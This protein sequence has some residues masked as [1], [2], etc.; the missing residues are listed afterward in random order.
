MTADVLSSAP[1]WVME[2][3]HDGA[4]AAIWLV[5]PMFSYLW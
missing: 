2:E 5:S 1:P 4:S 3:N